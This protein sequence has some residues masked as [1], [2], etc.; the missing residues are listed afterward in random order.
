CGGFLRQGNLAEAVRLAETEPPLLDIYN[1]LDFPERE[2]WC[3]VVAL[4]G[5]SVPPPLQK[6]FAKELNDAYDSQ[7]LLEPHLR[8]YRLAALSRAPLTYRLSLLREIAVLDPSNTFWIKDQETFEQLRLPDL[9]TEVRTAIKENNI[10][11]LNALQDELSQSWALT[12]PV[13][14]V[15]QIESALQ[16]NLLKDVERQM[17]EL[18]ELLLFAHAQFDANRGRTIYQNLCSLQTQYNFPVPQDIVKMTQ[19]AVNW[20]QEDAQQKKNLRQYEGVR[21]QMV[22]AMKVETPAPEL[23]RLYQQLKIAAQNASV[24][25]PE[26]IADAFEQNM[27]MQE[28]Q[29]RRRTRWITVSVVLVCLAVVG[30]TGLFAYAYMQ[31]KNVADTVTALQ[32]LEEEGNPENIAKYLKTNEAKLSSMQDGEVKFLLTKLQRIVEDNDRREKRFAEIQQELTQMIDAEDISRPSLISEMERLA[33]TE[34]E[35]TVLESLRGKFQRIE[36][37]RKNQVDRNLLDELS[38]IQKEI[39]NLANNKS[40]SLDEIK[41]KNREL[42][43]SLESLVNKYPNATPGHLERGKKIIEDLQTQIEQIDSQNA[44]QQSIQTLVS[45][46]GYADLFKTRLNEIIQ[47]FPDN[48]IVKQIETVQNEWN[49]IETLLKYNELR[50]LLSQF[51]LLEDSAPEDAQKISPLLQTFTQTFDDYNSSDFAIGSE[52]IHLIAAVAKR[53]VSQ[54]TGETMFAKTTETLIELKT[55]PTW[56]LFESQNSA[57][58]YVTKKP[59]APGNYSYV[60][61]NYATPVSK[62]FDKEFFKKLPEKTQSDIAER[63]LAL[64]EKIEQKNWT[65][66]CAS[67]I[68][69]VYNADGV[70]PILKYSL[71]KTMIADFS[72]Y[73]AIIAQ[74]YRPLLLNMNN[75]TLDE[76]VNRMNSE[77]SVTTAAR[78]QAINILAKIRLPKPELVKESFA[79]YAEEEHFAKPYRFR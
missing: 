68:H 46:I 55:H 78:R 64:L 3:D 14:L 59:V 5:Y 41:N 40:F 37:D 43:L 21:N 20:L 16:N 27:D 44:V 67:L 76:G 33:K 18:A 7:H 25:I 26:E 45:N 39:Q 22:A 72:E 42:I 9:E 75:K 15:F 61:S 71:M 11:Q 57:W 6:E 35:R 51:R 69:E 30:M 12:P 19:G 2:E 74:H 47:K 8:K 54:N 24:E 17:R 38:T 62:R 4:L 77:S 29:Y 73:D 13:N 23:Q 49:G 10:E 58:Y 66:A 65:L 56:E 53:P 34:E 52:E 79:K 50:R 70:D 36:R 1:V 60:T 48:G 63:G 28:L 32:K 31:H